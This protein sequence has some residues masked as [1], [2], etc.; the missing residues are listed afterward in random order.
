MICRRFQILPGLTL[1]LA[2]MEEFRL[3]METNGWLEP[4]GKH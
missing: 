4:A 2:A 1:V 3:W